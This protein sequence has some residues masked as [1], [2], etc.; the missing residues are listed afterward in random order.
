[1]LCAKG[2]AFLTCSIPKTRDATEAM[3]GQFALKLQKTKWKSGVCDES[4]VIFFSKEDGVVS[5]TG[6]DRQIF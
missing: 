6:L 4:V 2:T 3:A 5:T 1:M